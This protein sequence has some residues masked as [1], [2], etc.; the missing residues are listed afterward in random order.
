MQ[1]EVNG[2]VIIIYT[3][4]ITLG[5]LSVHDDAFSLWCPKQH[6]F[7]QNEQMDIR[8][9]LLWSTS[10]EEMITYQM[11]ALKLLQLRKLLSFVLWSRN[12]WDF[13]QQSKVQVNALPDRKKSARSISR[14]MKE[15]R[16]GKQNDPSIFFNCK[17]WQR[18]STE[19][20]SW[21]ADIRI[22]L[23]R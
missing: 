14:V 17:N 22:T 5:L 9:T 18:R 23:R 20:D 7:A 1:E 13:G 15:Y 16:G 3:V 4:T 21:I 19:E 10:Y 8:N 11:R 6:S 12:W 2:S